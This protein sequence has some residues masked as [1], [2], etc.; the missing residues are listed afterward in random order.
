MLKP[1]SP[2]KIERHIK[3]NADKPVWHKLASDEQI[4]AL[5]NN[6]YIVN[7]ESYYIE[8]SADSKLKP[9]IRTINGMD[10]LIVEIPAGNQSVNYSIIW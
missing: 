7:D 5:P 9:I 8:L 2:R 3:V 6:T 4:S 1:V 10:E